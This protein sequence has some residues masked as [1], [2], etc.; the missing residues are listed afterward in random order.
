[1]RKLD[2]QRSLLRPRPTPEYLEDETRAVDDLRAPLLLQVALLDGTERA[3]HHDE[4]DILG[5]HDP[6]DLVDFSAAEKG[7]RARRGQRCNEGA[8]DREIDRSGKA[9][10]LLE[11]GLGNTWVCVLGAGA[12]TASPA[13]PPDHIGADDERVR[14][15]GDLLFRFCEAGET[16]FTR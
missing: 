5:P 13:P 6:R 16:V 9:D 15:R 3:V 1:M 4:A 11:A 2:L 14:A 8:H 12:S 7:G 10:G